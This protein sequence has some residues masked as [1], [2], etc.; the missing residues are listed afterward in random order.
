MI[1]LILYSIHMLQ[2]IV[3]LDIFAFWRKRKPIF[4]SDASGG[5]T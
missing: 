5:G 4:P 1:V 2:L 3:L